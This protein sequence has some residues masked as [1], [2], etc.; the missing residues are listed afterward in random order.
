MLI[1]LSYRMVF[2]FTDKS[3]TPLDRIK[4]FLCYFFR[5]KAIFNFHPEVAFNSDRPKVRALKKAMSTSLKM[6]VLQVQDFVSRSSFSVIPQ[7]GIFWKKIRQ[8]NHPHGQVKVA[9]QNYNNGWNI[10]A[11][12]PI[13]KTLFPIISISDVNFI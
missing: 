8:S 3:L 5:T 7:V 12:S 2:H 10:K 6:Y 13:C 4:Q 1:F 9:S 11:H